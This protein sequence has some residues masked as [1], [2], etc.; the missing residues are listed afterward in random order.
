MVKDNVAVS[1]EGMV[2]LKALAS[3]NE[4][5]IKDILDKYG[6]ALEEKGEERLAILTV[7]NEFRKGKAVKLFMS[8]RK[9]AA[10]VATVYGFIVGTR[11]LWDKAQMIRNV[12]KGFIKKN[13]L[14]AAKEQGYINGDNEIL[15][16][17]RTV[18][19]RPNPKY[20][21]VLHPN[22]KVYD[23]LLYGFF[24]HNG[25]GKFKFGTLQTSDNA[26]AKA[27]DDAIVKGGRF[28]RP[29]QITAII[30]D[31]TDDEITL[32]ASTAEETKSVFRAVDEE[33]DIPKIVGE[34]M[35]PLLTKIEDVEG[36][37]IEHSENG[38]V[39]WN[40]KVFIKGVVAYMNTDRVDALGM[41]AIGIMDPANEDNFIKVRVNPNIIPLEFG[42]LS[43]VYVMG[44]PNRSMF[45][46][47]QNGDKLTEGQVVIDAY[48]L[49]ATIKT[50]KAAGVG[51]EDAEYDVPQVEGWLA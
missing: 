38:K 8:N 2:R 43:E 16:T 34:V 33:W 31:E 36:Y 18:F 21:E 13:S 19:G 29:C 39:Q 1:T 3:S 44:K 49:Y 48:G 6:A 20:G 4:V 17:R 23:M 10:N 37:F 47:R 7:V 30:K 51:G 26:I 5:P 28:F 35:D 27:W 41:V 46:D 32:T 22:L 45:K 25:D 9:N 14:E 12:A 24:R 40:A 11:G 15:D 50:P 42:E